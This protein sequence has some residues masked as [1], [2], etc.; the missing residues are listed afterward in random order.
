MTQKS[1]ST[2]FHCGPSNDCCYQEPM[3][4]TANDYCGSSM[5]SRPNDDHVQLDKSPKYTSPPQNSATD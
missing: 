4:L 2:Y 5:I 3:V 1:A